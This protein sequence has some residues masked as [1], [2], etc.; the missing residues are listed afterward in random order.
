MRI[1]RAWPW[2][3]EHGRLVRHCFFGADISQALALGQPAA[4]LGGETI[5]MAPMFGLQPEWW[6]ASRDGGLW[7]G[8]ENLY[9]QQGYNSYDRHQKETNVK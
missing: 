1:V 3:S 7:P 2:Q 8:D 9:H 5:P 4:E 6:E